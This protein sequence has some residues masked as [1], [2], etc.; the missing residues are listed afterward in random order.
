MVTSSKFLVAGAVGIL[1]MGASASAATITVDFDAFQ[2]QL[3]IDPISEDGVSLTPDPAVFFIEGGELF[4]EFL[5][6]GDQIAFTPAS[7][8][9]FVFTS[10]DYRASGELPGSVSDAF[11]ISGLVNGTE[12]FRLGSFATTSAALE[13]VLAGSLPPIDRL[14]LLG[15]EI[16]DQATYFDNFVFEVE[17]ATT[18]PIP[19]PPALALMA[20]SLFAG[21]LHTRRRRWAKK[22]PS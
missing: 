12:V 17:D 9:T 7:A 22:N 13:T 20:T 18:D 6:P 8:G 21:A 3:L 11:V 14:V 2:D 1:M 15:A 10:F 4:S 19:V 16:G 5:L